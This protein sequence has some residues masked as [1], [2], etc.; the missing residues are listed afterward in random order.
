MEK[1]EKHKKAAGGFDVDFGI[2]GLGG[3]FKGVEKL[4]DL[5]A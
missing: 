5:A 1:K 3:L 2:G 4:I